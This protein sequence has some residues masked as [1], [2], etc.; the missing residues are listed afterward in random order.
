MFRFGNVGG[1]VSSGV[2]KSGGGGFLGGSGLSGI[3]LDFSLSDESFFNLIKSTTL[4][5][6]SVLSDSLDG[7]TIYAKVTKNKKAKIKPIICP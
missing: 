1:A 7:F 3:V 6:F 2:T 5:E 4:K